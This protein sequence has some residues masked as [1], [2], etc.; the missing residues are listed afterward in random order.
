MSPSAHADPTA[1]ESIFSQIW[2]LL[3]FLEAVGFPAPSAMSLCFPQQQHH[4]AAPHLLCPGPEHGQ[5]LVLTEDEK[6]LLA[7]EGL[8]LP[9][10][11]PLTKVSWDSG[12]CPL[13]CSYLPR[14]LTYGPP[15][16]ECQAASVA[17][18][19]KFM[20]KANSVGRA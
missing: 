18:A 15:A 4:L 5:E 10:Q 13:S 7:K 8:T 2:C 1:D 17:G 12:P 16:L 9:T 14:S 11:L 6:K 3:H 19:R 20:L